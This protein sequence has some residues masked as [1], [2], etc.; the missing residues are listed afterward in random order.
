[1]RKRCYRIVSV[2]TLA[3]AFCLC[4][5]ALGACGTNT[6]KPKITSNTG[7]V[8]EGY[9]FAQGSEIRFNYID[10]ETITTA[11]QSDLSEQN[12]QKNSTIYVLDIAVIHN[13][14]PV[15]PDGNVTVSVPT[16]LLP[17]LDLSAQYVTFHI[18]DDHSIERLTTVISGEKIT[19]ETGSFSYFV[20]AE[21][22]LE[23]IGPTI[24]N[25]T[26]LKPADTENYFTSKK[27][28]LITEI[29]GSYKTDRPFTLDETD[30]NKRIY[31]DLYLYK[32]DFFYMMSS[33]YTDTW[34]RLFDKNDLE[35]VEVEREQGEDIQINVKVSGIYKLIFDT[36]TKSFDLEYK[37]EIT[38]PVYEVMEDC[39]I[40]IYQEQTQ[41]LTY[42]KTQ[43]VGD[44]FVAYNVHVYAGKLA[45]FYSEF[46][47][48]SWYNT[49]LHESSANKYVYKGGGDKPSTNVFFMIGGTYNIYI[50]PV[51]YVVRVELVSADADGYSAIIYRDADMN[52][53]SEPIE[54]QPADSTAPYLFEYQCNITGKQYGN[55]YFVMTTIP[56]IYTK[57]YQEY[58]LQLTEDSLQY[59]RI[60]TSDDGDVT[61]YFDNEGTH[62]L[63][64]NLQTFEI[65]VTY[66]PE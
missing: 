48:T 8:I 55:Y 46:T 10:D 51:T 41:K 28:Q 7:I 19:F 37:S 58:D 34:C 12:Y 43:A 61:Y 63:T 13:N 47:H 1:M 16:S 5:F 53:V 66:L 24:D 15:Q 57:N 33:D 62:I 27:L 40:G 21:A 60:Y 59:I 31:D 64:V 2:F 4:L 30:E 23:P 3:F 11:V 36:V 42:V 65:S 18:K 6:T 50:N 38:T 9:A 44:E 54:L 52:P 56:T 29:N 26:D 39:E 25:A 49:T 32:Y 35:Y 17:N 22:N 45:G 14:Q 20:L